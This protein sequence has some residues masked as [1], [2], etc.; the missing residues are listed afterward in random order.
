MSDRSTIGARSVGGDRRTPLRWVPWLALALLALLALLAFLIIRNAGDAGDKPGLDFTNDRVGGATE[1]GASSSGGQGTLTAADRSL[2][3]VSAA[4]SLSS[5]SGQAVTGKG[6][7]VESVVADEGFW[8]GSSASD[9]IFVSLLP[10]AR[11]SGGE[12]PFQVQRGQQVELV[13]KLRPVPTNLAGLGVDDAEGAAQLRSQGQY[14]EAT[15][16]RLSS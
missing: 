14:I 10:Q 1:S 7:V 3:P 13:G 16:V 8:V 4:G 5:L 2:L 11:G 15:S 6:V 12:S 9:R